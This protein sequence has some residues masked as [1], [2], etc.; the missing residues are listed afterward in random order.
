MEDRGANE[1][2]RSLAGVLDEYLSSI[3]HNLTQTLPENPR[4]DPQAY[5]DRWAALGDVRRVQTAYELL[6][7]PHFTPEREQL[8]NAAGTWVGLKEEGLVTAQEL[9]KLVSA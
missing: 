8:E 5:A 1:S 4:E 9:R 7:Y 2:Q 6:A 3:R